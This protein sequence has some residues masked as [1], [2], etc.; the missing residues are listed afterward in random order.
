MRVSGQ[1][2]TIQS[3][4]KTAAGWRVI[5]L[6]R[7]AVELVRARATGSGPL[8]TAPLAGG[9]RDPNNLSGNLRQLLDSFECESCR[10][11]GYQLDDQGD[12][13]LGH[14]K[15]RLRC[16]QGPWSWVTSHT[17]RKTVATR[18]DE[19]GL[20]PRQV[21]DQLGH[22]NPSMTLDVYF[23]RHVVSADTAHVLG[24]I[25]PGIVRHGLTTTD[26]RP[27]VGAFCA[28]PLQGGPVHEQVWH[29]NRRI[30]SPPGER[31]R[32]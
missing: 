5:A 9:L 6:P 27:R 31:I 26:L 21:A 25:T 2:L 22:A 19:A 30:A 29:R 20:T 3:R 10:G 7:F 15:Q 18:L 14:R 32:R 24:P 13:A 1:G 11:T 12:F 8:F 4:P 16:E 23:G 17:F 28:R